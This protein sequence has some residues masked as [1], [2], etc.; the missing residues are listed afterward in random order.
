M[1]EEDHD[2]RR[3]FGNSYFSLVSPSLKELDQKITF[4]ILKMRGWMSFGMAEKRTII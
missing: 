1:I 2:R 3:R 4:K